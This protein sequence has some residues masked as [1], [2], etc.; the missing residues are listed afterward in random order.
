MEDLDDILSRCAK[1]GLVVPG[2][3]DDEE[4]ISFTFHST[5]IEGSSLTY[6]EVYLLLKDNVAAQKA[7]EDNQ[8]NLDHADAYIYALERFRKEGKLSP[9]FIE[10]VCAQVM[11]NTG[12]EYTTVLG[13]WEESKGEYRKASVHVN[14]RYFPDQAKV[15]NLM[16]EVC[17]KFN[18]DWLALKTSKDALDLSASVHYNLVSVHPFSDGNGRTSRILMNCVLYA[19]DMPRVILEAENKGK[20]YEALERTRE[21]EDIGVFRKYIEENYKKQLIESLDLQKESAKGKKGGMHFTF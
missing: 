17:K 1:Q 8:M 2:R 15:E 7:L 4:K 3:I 6:D 5:S 11:L 18:E 19:K 10:D 16:N 21:K 12:K 9:E 14:S 20:Y 13:D